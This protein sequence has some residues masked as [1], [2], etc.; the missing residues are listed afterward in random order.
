MSLHRDPIPASSENGGNRKSYLEHAGVIDVRLAGRAV[1]LHPRQ[2]AAILIEEDVKI[3]C[4]ARSIGIKTEH[5]HFR[6]IPRLP[7]GNDEIV[8]RER[9][10]R[11]IRKLLRAST[12]RSGVV[13]LIIED[14]GGKVWP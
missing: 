3:I 9:T 4:R 14:Q 10:G 6:D 2:A 8:S 1:N 7:G 12:G 11:N 13:K 5:V